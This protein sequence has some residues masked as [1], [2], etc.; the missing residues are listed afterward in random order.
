M[1]GRERGRA[2]LAQVDD[3]QRRL[4]EAVCLAIFI[5]PGLLRLARRALVPDAD[6]GT[7]RDLWFGPLVLTRNATGIRLEP[8]ALAVLRSELS[9]PFAARAR[10]LVQEAH[11]AYPP[12][13]RLEEDIL[14]ECSRDDVDAA[15]R[16][17][18]RLREA[19]KTMVTTEPSRAREVARWAAQAWGRLP[20]MARE[21][22][23]ARQLAVGSSLRI[24]T[25][26]GP[27]APG[28]GGDLPGGLSWLS[29]ASLETVEIGVQV[30]TDGVRFVAPEP[31]GLV[32]RPPRTSPPVVE[33]AWQRA[34]SMESRVV[35][36]LVGTEAPLPEGWFDL[37]LKTLDGRRYEMR[38][39]RGSGG[40][41]VRRRRLIVSHVAADER[42]AEWVAWQLEDA[43]YQ[44]LVQVG[45]SSSGR[46]AADGIVVL[47]S[48]AYA[49]GGPP[50]FPGRTPV[51]LRIEDFGLTTRGDAGA[52]L[53]GLS[54]PEARRALLGA[55]ARALPSGAGLP[56]ARPSSPEPR[57]PR[58][59]PPVWNVPAR[60]PGFTGRPDLLQKLRDSLRSQTFAAVTA[61]DGM[62]GIG[63]TA[64]AVE[65][66]YRFI[67]DYD[68]VWWI[69][70]E[71]ASTI[72]AQFAALAAEAGWASVE[73]DLTSAVDIVRE[74]LAQTPRWLM[75][76]DNAEDFVAVGEW[77]PPGPGHVLITSRNSRW[78]DSTRSVDISTFSRAESI[79]FIQQRLPSMD[80]GHADRLAQALADLPLA[81]AQAVAVLAETALPVDVYLAELESTATEV[82]I[83]S[84][85][86][87]PLAAAL[88]ISLRRL[89]DEDSAAAQL[90]ELCA[91]FAPEPVAIEFFVRAASDL[92]EPLATVVSSEAELHRSVTLIGQFGLARVETDSLQLHRL[93]SALIRD[94]LG[95]RG[96]TAV[97]QEAEAVLTAAEPSDS[98]HPAFWSRWAQLLPH[99]LAVDPAASDNGRLRAM[100][101]HAVEYLLNRGDAAAARQLAETLHQ[102][103]SRLLGPDHNDTIAASDVLSQAY[104][105]LGRHFEAR[106]LG[107]DALARRRRLLGDD[108]PRTLATANNLAVSLGRLGEI[109]RA[110]ELYEDTL[111]RQRR[112][113]GGD[114][115]DTLISASNLASAL[116][117]LGE[118]ERAR[119]LDEDTFT[120]QRRVLGEDH[121]ET[122]KS[123]SNL[124]FDLTSLGDHEQGLR[125]F[126]DT[127][128][129]RRRVLGDDH[130]D[131]LVAMVDLAEGLDRQG[132]S[133]E[134]RT[135]LEEAV[136]R[137]HRVLGDDHPLSRM[138][139]RALSE[140]DTP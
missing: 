27:A 24:G 29:P 127:L 40:S 117:Q 105:Q 75:V 82:A 55:V 76:F 138:A 80:E 23:A 7:E 26:V 31:D 42:W 126:R 64:L 101:C 3:R 140:L 13:L 15:F 119:E 100:A 83:P 74:H 66:A 120:R 87:A 12:T 95:P 136:A 104:G 81:L 115:R 112:T 14:W 121:P 18:S 47:L 123:V 44:V 130:P 33:L 56:A 49:E 52:D 90:L 122:L 110:R 21:T 10:R 61:L 93:V 71:N 135:L 53:F 125:L 94:R 17:E 103:W 35:A 91:V 84:R 113:L 70:A 134:A 59:R 22:E 78:S 54:P 79:A 73:V 108:D 2:L 116:S 51:V 38:A 67:D 46:P 63:K 41:A 137:S 30:H 128:D 4:A 16:V 132:D 36:A 129:S 111:W 34:S 50:H 45:R 114:H 57:F 107:Q 72:G 9:L 58:S 65:Y 131:T 106:E 124:A 69:Q 28:V 102:S 1:S 11:R 60:D 39:G 62:G 19:V 109:Q 20:A 139:T 85:Y 68:L 5:E 77:L 48:Q 92:L 99:L 37:T 96:R 6:F 98:A 8:D 25:V 118:Y 89:A 88:G 32:I 97:R 133:A 43:G 86:P